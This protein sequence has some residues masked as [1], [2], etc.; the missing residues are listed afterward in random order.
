MPEQKKRG[1]TSPT[2]LEFGKAQSPTTLEF[3]KAGL[4][5]NLSGVEPDLFSL[6]HKSAPR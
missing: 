3:G 2:H 6:D 1:S 4:P 5:E